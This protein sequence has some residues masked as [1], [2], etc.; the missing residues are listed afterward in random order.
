[1]KR[2]RAV[3]SKLDGKSRQGRNPPR[4]RELG[5]ALRRPCG[6]VGP[7]MARLHPGW[8]GQHGCGDQAPVPKDT[9]A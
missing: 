4:G 3:R 1:M 2:E 9:P 8:Q 5:G 7:R 6:L